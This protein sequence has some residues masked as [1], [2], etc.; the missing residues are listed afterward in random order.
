MKRF[1][2]VVPP[3]VFWCC[4]TVAPGATGPSVA[5]PIAERIRIQEARIPEI[6]AVAAREREQVEQWYQRERAT[7]GSEIARREAARLCFSQRY[8][9]VQFAD[10]YRGRPFGP[11]SFDF[12]F[13]AGWPTIR[14]GQAM[15]QEYLI[16]EMA[17]LLTNEDFEHKLE[18][19]VAERLEAPRLALLRDQAAELL[20]VIRSV[21]TQA[22]AELAHLENLRDVRRDAIM[23]WEK[24]MKEQVRGFLEYLRQSES[25]PTQFGTVVSVGYCPADGYFCMVEGVDRVLGVGDRIGSVRI[26]GIDSE[27]VEFAKDGVTWSQAL[28]ASPKP[29]WE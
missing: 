16:S 11:T 9:W 24:D 8:L 27:K 23:N 15:I 21:R 17:D 26:L 12:G 6:E 20:R 14:L 13:G 28:G 5:P 25:R 4:G 18:Q 7:L 2:W 3:L 19:L 22:A 29:F 10:L 1:D